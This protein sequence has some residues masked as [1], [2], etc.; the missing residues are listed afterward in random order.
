MKTATIREAQHHLSKLLEQL[1]D[2]EEI[3]ITRRGQGVGKLVP[4]KEQR[5]V[6]F[7]DFT[8]VRKNL[9][10]DRVAG[11]NEVLAQRGETP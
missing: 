5:D 2:G 8:K 11:P 10:T 1:K 4:V 9:G 7:P 6:V 3:V